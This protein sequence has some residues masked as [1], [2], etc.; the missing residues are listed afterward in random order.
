MFIYILLSQFYTIRKLYAERIKIPQQ[1]LT[2]IRFY[3]LLTVV[4][5]NVPYTTLTS[6]KNI[7]VHIKIE[8]AVLN[9]GVKTIREK[10]RANLKKKNFCDPITVVFLSCQGSKHDSSLLQPI[11]QSLC[12][13]SYPAPQNEKICVSDITLLRNGHHILNFTGNSNLV[14]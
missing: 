4:K 1:S 14:V 6:T 11:V 12:P 10:S 3:L 7:F 13:M 5:T 9:V 2:S 8:A